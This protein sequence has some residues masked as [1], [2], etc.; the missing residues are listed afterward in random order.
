VTH[1][2]ALAGEDDVARA[3]SLPIAALHGWK[4]LKPCSKRLPLVRRVPIRTVGIRPPRVA[5]V[6]TDGPA[7]HHGGRP[8]S[9]H[10]RRRDRAAE[11]TRP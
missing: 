7:V 6:T 4:A 3:H 9:F 10:S 1:T 2:G 8:P 11:A 5:V